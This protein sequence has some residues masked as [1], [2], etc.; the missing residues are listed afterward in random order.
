MYS[1]CVFAVC[2]E[3]LAPF[4]II[5][6]VVHEILQR[7]QRA[8]FP[9]TPEFADAYIYVYLSVQTYLYMCIFIYACITHIHI[10]MYIYI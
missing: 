3:A 10:Y 2:A 7:R 9:E 4:E 6:A 1:T 5:T 8:I